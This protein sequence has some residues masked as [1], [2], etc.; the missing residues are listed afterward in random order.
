MAWFFLLLSGVFEVIG[1]TGFARISQGYRV[2][3]GLV[4]VLAFAAGLSCL[5]LAMQQIP[6]AVAYA[7]F[8]GIGAVGS[9]LVGIV[10]WHESARPG[11][12]AWVA[13]VIV[14]VV[15]LKLTM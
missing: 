4:A 9:T 6:M 5:Y 12:L 13:G 10:F 15:G 7:I 3:G 11:R 2:S 14:A 8:T 1:V